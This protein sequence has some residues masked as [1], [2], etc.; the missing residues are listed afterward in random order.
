MRVLRALVPT[1]AV[2]T[3]AVGHVGRAAARTPGAFVSKLTAGVGHTTRFASGVAVAAS[4]DGVDLLCWSTQ[5]AASVA[6]AVVCGTAKTTLKVAET[7]AVLT[8][9]VGM[10]AVG[11]TQ[12]VL[13]DAVRMVPTVAHINAL[14]DQSTLAMQVL[15]TAVEERCTTLAVMAGETVLAAAFMAALSYV[16]IVDWLTVLYQQHR[17]ELVE[18]LCSCAR[19]CKLCISLVSSILMAGARTLAWACG[20]ALSGLILVIQRH[21]PHAQARLWTFIWTK[22]GTRLNAGVRRRIQ[23]ALES[24]PHGV[25]PGHPHA[26]SATIRNTANTTM[27]KCA[28]VL[29][30]T[31][32]IVSPSLRDD[33][34]SA[35]RDFYALNDFQM[36][37][38]HDPIPD[39][40]ILLMTD[41]DYYADMAMWLSLGHPMLIYTF[42]PESA[43]GPVPEG[44]FFIEGDVVTTLISGGGEYKH[45]LWDYNHDSIWTTHSN[46]K[47]WYYPVLSVLS[48]LRITRAADVVMSSVDHYEVGEHRRIVSIVPYL[49]LPCVLWN[50]P[51]TQLARTKMSHRTERGEYTMFRVLGTNGPAITLAPSGLPASVTITEEEFY[52]TSTRFKESTSKNLSDVA[53]YLKDH[54]CKK[55]AMVYDYLEA[56]APKT[57]ALTVHAPGQFAKHFQALGPN[58]AEEGKRYAREYAPC[59]IS[60]AAVFPVESGNNDNL[61]VEKRIDLP[62]RL[63][64]AAIEESNPKGRSGV[65]PRRFI[66]YAK[67]FVN[68]LVKVPGSGTPVSIDEVVQAQNRP[69]QKARS[70]QRKMDWTE[71][72]RVQSFQKREPYAMPNDP[73]NIS[74]CP[75]THTLRLS[76]F[77]YPFKQEVLRK[78]C[79][80]MPC[81]NPSEIAQALMNF[82]LN[83]ED[84]DDELVREAVKQLEGLE[85]HGVLPGDYSRLDGSVTEWLRT[86]VEFP[87]Y[88]RW[89]KGEYHAELSELLHDELD[90]P[91]STKF[92]V[93][94]SPGASRL[95]GSPLT[96]DGNTIICA[97]VAYCVG[98]ELKLSHLW[99]FH[100]AGI[101]YGD[102]SVMS[103]V[104]ASSG[105]DKV[106]RVASCL[107]LT[108]KVSQVLPHNP[109][110]FLARV[111]IDP[112]TTPDSC[113]EPLRA[114]GKIHTTVDTVN[115]IEQIGWQKAN[116]ILVTDPN[117]PIVSDWC[118]AYLRA[119]GP[120]V[121]SDTVTGDLP[122]WYRDE[123]CRRHPW[124]N[125]GTSLVH[126]VATCL[127]KR[128]DEILAHVTALREYRGDIAGIPVLD[129][130][131]PVAK[132]TVV[133]DGQIIHAGASCFVSD[134]VQK[135]RKNGKRQS[136][137]TDD[138]TVTGAEGHA[139]A[140]PP[141]A[142]RGGR[143][144]AP[145]ANRQR[146]AS[147]KRQPGTA[148][149][150]REEL[151]DSPKPANKSTG[152]STNTEAG[153]GRRGG[154][155]RRE[156]R[157]GS[158]SSANKPQKRGQPQGGPSVRLAGTP[159]PVKCTPPRA[160]Q[161]KAAAAHT[162]GLCTDV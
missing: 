151:S 118:R 110:P 42:V 69:T 20:C 58:T 28:H 143:G 13:G 153:N 14:V 66:G 32:Y 6:C 52:A 48:M 112:W 132:A 84:T 144:G 157:A 2:A 31:P 41:V 130:Q 5:A 38:R 51:T 33:G 1:A 71:T 160:C 18:L 146:V 12:I 111:F 3:A 9:G 147:P 133:V 83:A 129:V 73:R 4:L 82:V 22:F 78:A 154:R 43:G 127:G 155:P 109:V 90:A 122:W 19:V 44:A 114:L 106:T 150:V 37:A 124:P 7:S 54:D 159:A 40:P 125:S 149:R 65:P 102:D 91:A 115:P 11:A 108:L 74:T 152:Q 93:K 119:A 81:K 137:R 62:Q 162:G 86:N 15:T 77:T 113:V 104:L 50:E 36:T 148:G 136:N 140:S 55:A 47:R 46:R 72:F 120:L 79:W 45:R 49:R 24:V 85:W 17:D 92:G 34:D 16:N 53:R 138:R 100:K 70:A 107:G 131:E 27:K 158:E 61:C 117:T 29:G 39:N 121:L 67:D 94:Y 76:T 26:V 95:S 128:D 97:F 126:V 63:A 56:H 57:P 145:A 156:H 105:L 68:E 25:R 80:Y 134:S 88:L 23:A 161:A 30:R 89:V 35:V 141:S 99:S 101:Y 142:P 21:E 60:A 116:A 96:T 103:G 87:A 59:P 98:R 123:E 8:L 75:T 139:G 135:P 10:A 64:Y